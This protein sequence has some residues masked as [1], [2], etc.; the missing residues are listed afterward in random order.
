MKNKKKKGLKTQREIGWDL[1][2]HK[3]NCK[4]WEWPGRLEAL[5]ELKVLSYFLP[6][7]KQVMKN[8]IGK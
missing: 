8:K 2:S 3:I 4:I 7:A 1:V 6:P 5:S